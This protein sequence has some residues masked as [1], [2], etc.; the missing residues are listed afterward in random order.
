MPRS[1]WLLLALACAAGAAPGGP[2]RPPADAVVRGALDLVP[3]DDPFPI[4]RVRAADA[5][6]PE[7]LK[8]LEPGPVVRL[9]RAEFE[10]RVRGAGRAVAQAKR[11]ARVVDALYTAAFDGNDLTGTA[12]LGVLNAD[13]TS[14]FLP[15]DPLKVAV[16]GAKWAGGGDAVLAVPPGATAPAVWVTGEG[17]KT[18]QFRW[19]LAGATEPGERRFELRVP[20]CAASALE[21]DLP[22]DRAPTAPAD[23]LLTGPFDAPGKP[24]RRLWRFRFGG[25]SKLEFAVRAGGAPSVG[26]TAALVARY[27]LG[28]GQLAAA[29]EYELRPARG[30]VGEWTFLVDPGV[31]VTEVVANNRAGWAVEPPDAPN[32]PRLLRVRLRQP[33]S[34]GKVLVTAVA[35]FP[36]PARPDAPLPAVRPVGAVSESELLELRLAPGLRID[37]WAAGDYHLTDATTASDQTRVL[38]LSGA[39]SAPGTDEPFRRMPSVRASFPESEFATSERLGWFPGATGSRLVARVRVRV[40]RGPLVQL[41]V[42]PPAG[43]ALD[44]NAAVTDELVAHIGAP[45]GGTQVVELARPLLTGQQ[46]ELQLEFR[47]PGVKFGEPV[48]FPALGVAGASERDGWLSVSAPLSWAVTARP[49][50]GASVAGL[51][52]WFVTDAPADARAVYAYRAKEPDGFATFEVARPKLSAAGVVALAQTGDRWAAT[53]RLTLS[54]TGPVAGVMAFVP[55]PRDERA[56]KLIDPSNA[57]LE[58]VPIPPALLAAPLLGPTDLGAALVGA[59][60]RAGATDGT[61]WT[62]RFARPVSAGAVLETSAPGP[63][64]G[65]GEF[66]LAVPRLVG[67]EQ[68]VRVELPPALKGVTASVRGDEVRVVRS[69]DASAGTPRVSDAYLLTAVRSPGEVVAAFGGLVRD[70]IGGALPVGLPAGAEVRGVCVGGRWLTPSACAPH[71]DG[72][73][74]VPVPAGPAVRFEVRYRLAPG[75]GWPTRRVSSPVPTTPGD[76]PVSRWWSFADGVLPGWPSRPW[77]A[78]ADQPPLLGG[79]LTSGPPALVTR[80]DDEWVRV[81]T[82]RA[83]DVFA[84]VLVALL[85]AFGL[86]AARRGARGALV[87]AVVAALAL[88]ALELGPPWWARAA[89]P[90]LCAAVVALARV[91]LGVRLRRARA[92]ALLACGLAL[93][94]LQLTAQQQPPATVVVVPAPDGGEEVAAPR[95]LLDRL[96]ALARPAPP[97]PVV[98]AATYDVRTDDTG[99]RVTARFVVHALRAGENTL[100]LP[101]TDARLERVT[102]NGAPAFTAAARPDLFTVPLGGQGRYEVEVRFAVAVAASGGDRELRFGVPEAADATVSAALAGA[103]RQPQL[104]GRL[105]RQTVVTG[106]D[107]TTVEADLGPAKQVHLRWREGAGGAPVVKVREACVWDVT[108]GGAE[109]TA[110]YLVRVEQGTL[111]SLRFDVPAELE[112][113]RVAVRA[114]DALGAAPALRDWQ[115]A[116]EKGGTRALRIDLQAPANGRFLMLLECAPRKPVTRQPVLRFPRPVFG[117]E[118]GEPAAAYA[119]RTARIT[120]DEIATGGVNGVA[121]EVLREFVTVPDLKLDPNNLPRSFRPVAGAVAEL[122][123]T[124]RAGEAL[125]ARAVTSWAVGPRGADATGTLSWTA[126]SAVALVEFG[127]G[128]VKVLEVRGPG[129]AGWGQSGGRVQVW[130]RAGA[131]E[132]AIE[133]TGTLPSGGKPGAEPFTFEPP[134]L[135]LRTGARLGSSEVRVRPVA[136]WNVRADRTRGWQTVAAPAGELRV[137]ADAPQPPALRVQVEPER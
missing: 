18:L 87:L 92:A 65:A 44:R 36:D 45:S 49:G 9:P 111:T 56:W 99:A 113:L 95:A 98:A 122:R 130:L 72:S 115:L 4:R 54:A 16:R 17:R 127:L 13:G 86:V 57:L 108:D 91:L 110:A 90:V 20:T 29:F 8:E 1:G 124:L 67:A 55:G 118:K 42:R 39:L 104:V 5:K 125:T 46:A 103:A 68:S 120:A 11:A 33:G 131:K 19:S 112:V 88:A 73:I 10:N 22:A 43:F 58:A 69:G 35:P 47:G 63:A 12:D 89:W 60:R 109:L 25:R 53:T 50:S 70:S 128:G 119:L 61:F 64:A 117:S 34:G 101:L 136:G 137:R 77:N 123:P 38:S 41:V 48:P 116:P 106:E 2:P 28:Q 24:G 59:C 7:V 129:V 62:L 75:S 79:P 14:H 37:S 3:A 66:A 71:A 6:L 84:V 83:A 27:E 74:H 32:G 132:G 51:W 52:G 82:V 105:G 114:P 31:R 102:V 21:L 85:V 94:S 40:A 80:S 15:L 76:P 133:W 30:S 26:A 126:G 135:A 23:V 134:A 81:G 78:T 96:D 97:A 107:R 100:S 121:D 93:G